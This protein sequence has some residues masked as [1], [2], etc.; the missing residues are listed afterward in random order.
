MTIIGTDQPTEPDAGSRQPDVFEE[1]PES[2]RAD[3]RQRR[4]FALNMDD[5]IVRDTVITHNGRAAARGH[6]GAACSRRRRRPPEEPSG[7][8]AHS[9]IGV[10]ENGARGRGD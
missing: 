8:A 6:Q 1:H 3:D 5:D 7:S 4:S 10:S 2:A 9:R